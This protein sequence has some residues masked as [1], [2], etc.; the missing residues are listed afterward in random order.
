MSATP[1]VRMDHNSWIGPLPMVGR[2]DKPK[3]PFRFFFNNDLKYLQNGHETSK[4]NNASSLNYIILAVR[5]EH[6][7]IEQMKHGLFIDKVVEYNRD[8]LLGIHHWHY[9]H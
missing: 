8:A 3:I 7:D 5:Y 6:P 4:H 2:P 1:M 9:R